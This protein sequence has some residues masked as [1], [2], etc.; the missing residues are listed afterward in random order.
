MS[1]PPGFNNP[2]I[3]GRKIATPRRRLNRASSDMSG[4]GAP[5]PNFTFQPPGGVAPSFG[6]GASGSAGFQFSAPSQATP[7]QQQPFVFGSQA[8]GLQQQSSTPFQFGAG[9]SQPSSPSS[10]SFGTNTAAAAPT[11]AFGAAAAPTTTTATTSSTPSFG[12][13]APATSSTSAAPSSP[14]QQ[15]FKFGSPTSS[16]FGAGATSTAATTTSPFG[17]PSLTPA[18]PTPSTPPALGAFGSSLSSTSSTTSPTAST[19][20]FGAS[21][22]QPPSSP[23]VAGGFTFGAGAT[24]I[25]ATGDSTMATDTSLA[26]P[27]S[28]GSTTSSPSTMIK[29]PSFNFGSTAATTEKPATATTT[30]TKS[31]ADKP[32]VADKPA[33][34]FG[35]TSPKQGPSPFAL[36]STTTTSSEK[37]AP[38]MTTATTTT[39][40]SS[41]TTPTFNFGAAATTTDKSASSST[42]AT[43]KPAF[44]FGTP[45]STTSTTAEKPPVAPKMPTFSFGSAAGG[46]KD[47]ASETTST[48]KEETTVAPVTTG[49]KRKTLDTA[50]A[51]SARHKLRHGNSPLSQ[52][53][54]ADDEEQLAT[55]RASTGLNDASNRLQPPSSSTEDK[56]KDKGSSDTAT[57]T[58][59]TTT[60][61]PA[62]AAA[63]TATSSTESDGKKRPLEGADNTG[64]QAKKV[65]FSV[66]ESSSSTSSKKSPFTFGAKEQQQDGDKKATEKK[67]DEKEGAT[68]TT[69]TK[70]GD[71]EN[72]PVNPFKPLEST[73]IEIPSSQ[74]S[75][76]SST[77][78][79]S[80]S[81]SSDVFGKP[82]P[83]DAEQTMIESKITHPDG[84]EKRTRYRELPGAAQT[85]LD[86]LW[87]FIDQQVRMAK[88]IETRQLASNGE[89]IRDLSQSVHR[90]SKDLTL[91]KEQHHI[92]A[93]SIATLTESTEYQVQN[94]SVAKAYSDHQN[95]GRRMEGGTTIHRRYFFDLVKSLN[96][97]CTEYRN[98]INDIEDRMR[99]LDQVV[100]QSP[101]GLADIL[102]TQNETLIALA[103]Q[104][105]DLHQ[106]TE[107]L[108]A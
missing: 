9:G 95:Q 16:P 107:K 85:E 15:P 24:P 60:T 64:T 19:F 104:V 88:E 71:K 27:F 50:A 63:T 89:L 81:T 20:T 82:T 34:S 90:M 78:P 32:A 14:A 4:Q 56:G 54:N 97:K 80:Q 10:F 101:A 48:S 70:E 39:S 43:T 102:R 57:T 17:S 96:A 6:G 87:W 49:S 51:E 11:P 72:K 59:T 52:S 65:T 99:E 7:S 46:E 31:T 5:M 76:S 94:A 22:Q 12:T 58:T 40:S 67:K 75:S 18:A 23:K 98:A 28:I 13:S 47:G 53:W 44:S 74:A 29:T 62:A 61:T 84:I 2:N 37:S 38:A 83:T 91:L 100:V 36:T 35:S 42:T 1:T 93:Q 69:T 21:A 103:A 92:T 8:S 25:A 77:A 105:A 106:Q 79:K 33:F 68:T 55:K 86:N 26:Q 66:G 3:A 108:K 41:S 30:T 45:A 73:P